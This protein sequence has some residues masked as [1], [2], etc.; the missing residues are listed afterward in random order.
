M[1]HKLVRT[2][3]GL[4]AAIIPANMAISAEL[5]TQNYPRNVINAGPDGINVS[6][7][8]DNNPKKPAKRIRSQRPV[9]TES[10]KGKPF[11]GLTNR[12]PTY[13]STPGQTVG[14]AGTTQYRDQVR[15]T[16]AD[17]PAK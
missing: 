9:F 12:Q 17:S 16:G 3:L 10:G 8:A 5:I 2:G 11:E 1:I 7:P 13:T 4:F 14:A 15:A 6:S